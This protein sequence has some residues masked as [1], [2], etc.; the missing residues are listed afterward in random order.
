[1][2]SLKSRGRVFLRREKREVGQEMAKEAIQAGEHR[3]KHTE[4]LTE[5]K[6][7]CGRDAVSRVLGTQAGYWNRVP[8]NEYLIAWFHFVCVLEE[9]S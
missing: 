3:V 1:M 8:R 5:V 9:I 7:P 6:Q 4:E 2:G